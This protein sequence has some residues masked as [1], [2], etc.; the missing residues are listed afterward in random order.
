MENREGNKTNRAPAEQAVATD[1][2]KTKTKQKVTR[3][4]KAKKR[5]GQVPE[6]VDQ[7]GRGMTRSGKKAPIFW[8]SDGVDGGKS[9]LRVVLEWMTNPA[10][11]NKWRGSDR[12]SGKMKEALLAEIVAQLKAVGI[13]HRDSPGVREKINTSD[14]IRINAVTTRLASNYSVQQRGNQ[15]R[16]L[17]R[18]S[19]QV[20][21]GVPSRAPPR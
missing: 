6:Q 21:S 8:D 18:P 14:F 20:S 13:E 16:G 19:I 15:Q 11:Y 3:S 1:K 12:T 7:S 17:G 2:P 5:E 10:N 9:S 4:S